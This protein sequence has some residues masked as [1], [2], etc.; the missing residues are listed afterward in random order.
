MAKGSFQAWSGVRYCLAFGLLAVVLQFTFQKLAYHWEWAA[1]WEYR[2][3]FI[4]GW[5]FTLGLSACSLMGSVLLG[6]GLA[7]ARRSGWPVISEVARIYVEVIR[8]T[9]LLVQIL[10]L[11]YGVFDQV[12]ITDRFLAGVLILSGFAGAYLSEIIRAGIEGV[13]ASQ[14]ESARAIGLSTVQTYRYVIFP[15]ALRAILPPMAGQFASLVKDSSLLSIIGIGEF[16]R[17]AQDVNSFTY[18]TLESYLPLALGYLI[19]TLPIS[20]WTQA[21][22]KKHRFD[23]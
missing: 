3:L 14:I 18:G 17:A 22:E 1:V 15:Q 5:L 6:T 10:I 16:T 13:G 21:L 4:N 19:L 9:P 7:L 8:G 12:G 11:F 20:L 23:T 2:Q